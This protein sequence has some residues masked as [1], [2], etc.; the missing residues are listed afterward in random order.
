M[1]SLS[2]LNTASNVTLSYTD[3]R[4]TIIAFDRATPISPNT[5]FT[6]GG[7]SPAGVGINITSI[8]NPGVV[9]AYYEIDVSLISGATVTWATLPA[10]YTATTVSTGLYRVTGIQSAADWEVIK[11]ATINAPSGRSTD[12]TYTSKIVFTGTY[13]TVTSPKTW[14]TTV[15]YTQKAALT[16]AFSQ[17]ATGGIA[18]KIIGSAIQAGTFTMLTNAT[19]AKFGE[20]NLSTTISISIQALRIKQSEVILTSTVATVITSTKI[21]GY[22]TGLVTTTYIANTGNAVFATNTPRITDDNPGSSTFTITLTSPAGNFGTSTSD[23]SSYSFSGTMS[24]VNAQF[25]NIYFWPTKNY[26]SNSTFTYTQSKAGSQ[27]ITKTIT[28]NYNS[29]QTISPTVYSF[30]TAGT[31]TWTPTYAEYKYTTA[32]VLIVGGGGGS[33]TGG[34]Y[35]SGGGGGQV[36]TNTNLTITGTSLSITVGAGGATNNTVYPNDSSNKQYFANYGSSSSAFGYTAIGGGRASWIYISGQSGNGGFGGGSNGYAGGT[37]GPTGPGSGNMF[38]AGAGGAGNSAIGGNPYTVRNGAGL[39]GGIG[40]AGTYSSITGSSLEYGR[41]GDGSQPLNPTTNDEDPQLS[42]QTPRAN[43]GNG[44]N[45]GTVYRIGSY[46][47]Y[48]STDG[49][50]GIVIIK[51]HV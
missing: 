36:Y 4:D 49:A 19:K 47:S 37:S 34:M 2:Q 29:T 3:L 45:G 17:T 23:S 50:D 32:D 48:P 24:Q 30:T 25:A 6:T 31:T 20:A 1:N 10:G 12:F 16:S 5:A 18:V 44:G 42:G 22:V 9:N 43:S 33:V 46:T 8:I 21:P 14:T 35:G 38:N 40:G 39:A 26:T 7:P 11:N 15:K 51:T 13:G 27:Q 41:G 28:L